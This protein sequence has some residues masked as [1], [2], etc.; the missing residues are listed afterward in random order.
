MEGPFSVGDVAI[1][2]NRFAQCGVRNAYRS[3]DTVACGAQG[4]GLAKKAPRCA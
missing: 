4:P 2:D 1:V 3:K